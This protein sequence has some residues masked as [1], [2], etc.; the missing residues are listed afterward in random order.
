MYIHIYLCI[1]IYIYI[2]IYAYI[3][4]CRYMWQD[5]SL[6]VFG[7]CGQTCVGHRVLPKGLDSGIEAV[8]SSGKGTSKRAAAIISGSSTPWRSH[9][10]HRYAVNGLQQ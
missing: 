3:K 4:K 2:H 6:L 10:N 7:F 8:E 1:H 5:A 9:L